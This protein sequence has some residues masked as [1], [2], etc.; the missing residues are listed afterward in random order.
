MDLNRCFSFV[1]LCLFVTLVLFVNAN[2]YAQTTVCAEVRI[3]IAQE[4]TIE[5]QAFEAT[6][7]I[8]NTLADQTISDINVDV[9]FR[10]EDGNDVVAT[11]DPN[12]SSAD[13][14]IRVNDLQGIDDI[15]GTGSLDAG[16]SALATW[17][18]IP[19]P[20][21]SGGIPSGK[22]YFVSAT[23]E[24]TLD[25]IA[26][27]IDVAPDT[28]FVRPVPELTL[29]YFLPRD[30]FAD[31]PLTDEVEAPEPFTLGVRVQN[32]GQGVGR[33]IRIESAQPEITENDQGLLID[34][35]LLNS[36]VQNEQVNNSLLID[37][38]DIPAD[39]S[40][41]GRWSMQTTL[42]GRFTAFEADFS[43]EDELG[44]QLT[45]LI[46]GVNTHTLVRDVLVDLQ[47]RDDVKDFLAF[48]VFDPLTDTIED[49]KVYESN[50]ETNSVQIQSD[51][52]SLVSS[53]A[54]YQL[55]L[56]ENIGFVYAQLDDPFQGTKTIRS[57][58]RSD[59]KVLDPSNVW[60]SRSYN[61]TSREISFHF[62]IFDVA[63][64][65][66]YTVIFDNIV[67]S[68]LPPVIQF[69]P[70]Q[71]TNA[72]S[73][74][75]FLIQSSDPNGDDVSLSLVNAPS[76]A[77]L[78]DRLDGTAIFSWTPS[79]GQEGRYEFQVQADD[80]VSVTNQNIVVQ[81]IPSL[82]SDGDGLLDSYELEHFGTLDRDG[83][84]DFDGDGVS[85]IDELLNGT[86]PTVFDEQETTPDNA[87]PNL[88]AIIQFLLS[89]ESGVEPQDIEFV[90]LEPVAEI[91]F[92]GE[93]Q[94]DFTVSSVTLRWLNETQQD[95]D[96]AVSLYYSVS[97]DTSNLISITDQASLI[98][99]EYIWTEIPSLDV[100]S[101]GNELL[102]AVPIFFF[103]KVG[104]SS[105]LIPAGRSFTVLISN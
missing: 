82:D 28:I 55:T 104:N 34:F 94:S 84:G 103:A 38:G 64:T 10:D 13:F 53:G 48:D 9:I 76:G 81:V 69:I 63:T 39:E 16:Q 98:E 33:N 60:F 58:I 21:S 96:T 4:L 5:R 87:N 79:N 8:E 14:F 67:I 85:D 11:N 91:E 95:G 51:T 56:T 99:E 44:G 50:S 90:W 70:F 93:G 36:F 92:F 49:L 15:S 66:D 27:Q 23:F 19:V 22:L 12:S 97:S 1:R 80:G 35:T 17:L 83:T 42:S 2:A 74:L 62:N 105:E 75:S 52:A 77:N 46:D 45:S 88:S 43:H 78:V 24:Y 72:Q 6:L 57:V 100:L 26:D 29:D 25:G 102:E 101:E 86:D 54:T 31:D 71:T 89:A 47:G 61:R 30:V 68:E 40:R 3:E 37:F 65:G 73:L 32:N 7:L 18:I 59:G 41:V 20:G